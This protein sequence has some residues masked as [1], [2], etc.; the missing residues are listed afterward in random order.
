MDSIFNDRMFKMLLAKAGINLTSKNERY[1]RMIAAVILCWLPL[2]VLTLIEGDFWTGNIQTSFITS[3]DTQIRILVSLPIFILA[4]NQVSVRLSTIMGQFKN[5][6]IIEK[7]Q[8]DLFDNIVKK[9][10]KFLSSFWMSF[11]V[12]CFC[13]LQVFL[14]M[15]YE[16]ENTFLLTWQ[17]KHINGE[18]LLSNA[19][20]WSTLISRPIVLF[21]FYRWFIAIITWG[22]LLR[23]ISKLELNLFPMHPDLVG[24]LGFLGYAIRYF[25]PITFA[26]SATVAANLIDLI[27]I[28]NIS[29]SELR[30]P[31]LGFFL[32]INVLLTYPLL[33]FTRKL[34]D[35]RERSVFENDDF[36]NGML[37]EFRG[38]LTN[39]Y[40]NVSQDDLQSV[41]YSSVSDLSSIMNN[42]LNMK[43]V[44]LTIKD[45]IPL[46]A[47][48]VIPLLFV[49]SFE[50]PL[51]KLIKDILSLMF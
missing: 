1:W 26:I 25:S 50:I 40:Y 4:E 23:K 13:Y 3:F 32:F 46:W 27:I 8:H 39:G 10:S 7:E 38:T 48:I 51:D 45:L 37:R 35:A 42:A 22:I 33:W 34:I 31:V 30:F 36:A 20:W 19:G 6:G 43:F 15:F 17:I 47:S 11:T 16:S 5:S 21:V 2:A 49:I 28:E 14:L 24:G 18:L 29:L 9:N 12:F 41:K 44:P